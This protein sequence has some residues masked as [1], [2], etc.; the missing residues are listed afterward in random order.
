MHVTQDK[1]NEF[2]R[3]MALDRGGTTRLG[4]G[5][6]IALLITWVKPIWTPLYSSRSMWYWAIFWRP[7]V[8]VGI[9]VKIIRSSSNWVHDVTKSSDQ[10]VFSKLDYQGVGRTSQKRGPVFLRMV[11]GIRLLLWI[12][13]FLH[14]TRPLTLND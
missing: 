1:S 14:R 9:A 4:P 5:C 13:K 2:C 7:I 10:Y 3:A 8:G 12:P 11:A 6:N